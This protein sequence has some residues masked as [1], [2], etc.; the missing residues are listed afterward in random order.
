MYLFQNHKWYSHSVYDIFQQDN[1]LK[2]VDATL[3]MYFTQYSTIVV[4][5]TKHDECHAYRVIA[6]MFV[7][8]SF[9]YIS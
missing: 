1:H 9:L 3:V 8:I 2:G 5:K 7:I 4:K 6:I